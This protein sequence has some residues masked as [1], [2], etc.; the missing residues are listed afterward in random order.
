MST[1]TDST[2][3]AAEEQD[4]D[5]SKDSAVEIVTAE[6]TITAAEVQTTEGDKGTGT[7]HNLTFESPDFPY[8]IRMGLYVSYE[9]ADPSTVEMGADGVTPKWVGRQRGTLKNIA[10]A[11]LGHTGYSLNPSSSNYLVGKTVQATTRDDGS[12][13]ATLSKFRAVK[14]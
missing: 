3:P 12:G 1:G 9:P 11:A 10:K 2:I 14:R 7:R 8:E 6:F 13:F 4:F 5:F